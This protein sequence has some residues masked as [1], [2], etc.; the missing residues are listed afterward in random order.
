MRVFPNVT[1][2]EEFQ[3][4]DRLDYTGSLN[5]KQYSYLYD[6]GHR[7]ALPDMFSYYRS[8]S[9]DLWLNFK[10]ELFLQDLN[11]KSFSDVV[12]HTRASTATYVDADGILQTAAT[13]V[14]R[15][16]HH[17]WNGSAWVNEG[18]LHESEARTNLLLNSDTLSTQSVT[19][20]AAAHTLHFTGT[21]TIT[22]SGVSTDGPLVGT[23]TG[24]NNRVYLTFT[25]TAGTLTLTVT[26][27]V[28]NAQLEVGPTPSSYIPT[29]GSAVTRAADVLT[30]P[31]ANL[32]YPTPTVIGPE[33]VTNGDGSSATGWSSPRANSTLSSVDGKLRSTANTAAAFGIVQGITTE[34]G[35]VYSIDLSL[36]ANTTTSGFTPARR[37]DDNFDLSS[38]YVSTSF[39]FSSF[40]FVARDTTTY[41]GVIAVAGAAGEY[42]EIDNISVREINPLAV[43]IQ[44]DGRVTYADEDEVV[45]VT[46]VRWQADASNRI[47]SFLTTSG[48][49]TGKIGFQ[50]IASGTL[51]S[52]QESG[53]SFT[54]SALFPFNIASRHGS[55]FINGAL[56]GT[57]L[58]ANITPVALP[59]LATT[60][61]N[62]AFEYMG[63]IR[64]FRMWGQDITDAGLVEATS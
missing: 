38:G 22:L 14:P 34:V 26:G 12:T 51:D 4:L 33:L 48:G 58:T 10:D 5:D 25:P 16:G 30:V 61:M 56:N 28:S 11:L 57:A 42:I 6:R 8:S 35:K 60:N 54:P 17:V 64:T 63:T 49:A 27:T 50:Q 36:V 7:G 1:V 29:A 20:T 43:S 39:N 3:T 55:T 45:A 23:G 13:N 9:A 44:M 37:I 2:D 52:V 46:F 32:P 18:L 19:V 62:F 31:A 47:L 40:I 21:G 59:N 15:I 53:N 41:L 24:E